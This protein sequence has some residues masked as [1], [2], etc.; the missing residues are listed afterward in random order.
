MGAW[1]PDRVGG[2]KWQV[3]GDEWD[4]WVTSGR[5]DTTAYPSFP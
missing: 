2:D 1:T 4:I 3:E 5:E